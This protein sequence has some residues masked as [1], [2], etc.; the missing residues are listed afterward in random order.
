[1]PQSVTEFFGLASKLLPDFDG[2][3]E[4]LQFSRRPKSGRFNQRHSLWLS[5]NLISQET[6]LQEIISKWRTSVKGEFIDVLVVKFMK[7]R[8]QGKPANTYGKEIED[9][10]KNVETTYVNDG[11]PNMVAVK[12][13]TNSA[14]K[15]L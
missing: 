11:L 13:A 8:Q 3:T 10:T 6:T 4:N 5:G 12:Y 1:M 9:L 7:I 14:L 15:P 2:T